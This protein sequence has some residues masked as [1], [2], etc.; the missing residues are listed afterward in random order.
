M[1]QQAEDDSQIALHGIKQ[2]VLLQ[3]AL[4]P[5]T[6]QILKP[7][8]YLLLE[9]PN[10]FPPKFNVP[11]HEH[12]SKWT[13]L[14]PDDVSQSPGRPDGEKLTKVMRKLRLFLHPDKL[15]RDFSKEQG[16]LCK[17]LWDITSDAYEDFK[18]GQEDLSWIT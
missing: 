4:R 11:H 1:A 13:P 10:V 3:W 7:I 8:D 16:H 12:F 18:K 14:R 5:P 17:L 9:M 15:P 6:M 2:G